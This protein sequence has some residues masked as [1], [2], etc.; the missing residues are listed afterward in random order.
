SFF[1]FGA[2]ATVHIWGRPRLDEQAQTLR[3]AD[4]ELAV[5]SEAAFGLLGA[6]ARAAIPHMQ[7]ALADRLVVDLKP[8]ATNA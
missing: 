8:F 3:L 5:E 4:V 1:G 2:E 7:Q 6:A